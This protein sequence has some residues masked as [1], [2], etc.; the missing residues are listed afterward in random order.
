MK[1]VELET[2]KLIPYEW[3]NK[4]HDVTQVDR[5]ANSIKEFGFKNPILV[6]KNNIIIA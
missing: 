4:I 2:T 1:V 3:N 5:I 6:D